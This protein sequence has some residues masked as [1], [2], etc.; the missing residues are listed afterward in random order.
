LV[1]YPAVEMIDDR[2]GLRVI[3]AVLE[4]EDRLAA[5]LRSTSAAMKR[6]IATPPAGRLAMTAV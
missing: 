1:A 4:R 3:P 6:K 5:L 2:T